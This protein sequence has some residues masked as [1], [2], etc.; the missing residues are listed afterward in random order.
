MN[1]RCA[2]GV[3]AWRGCSCSRCGKTRNEGHD[4]AEN[5]ERCSICG[6]TRTNHNW[7]RDCEK[8]ANCRVTRFS[9]HDWSK[10]CEKCAA[11]GRKR[12]NAHDWSQDVEK[13]A[14]C[15][16]T[17]VMPFTEEL[18][19][20]HGLDRAAHCIAFSRDDNLIAAGDDHGYI[21][22]WDLRKKEQMLKFRAHKALVTDI[23]FAQDDTLLVSAANDS[24]VC[25]LDARTGGN[26]RR[27]AEQFVPPISLTCSPNGRLLAVC[28]RRDRVRMFRL[29]TCELVAAGTVGVK[30]SDCC[31]ERN[32]AIQFSTHVPSLFVGD[33]KGVVVYDAIKLAEIK[34]LTDWH[35]PGPP[36]FSFSANGK[37][38]A[39][40][41]T[42]GVVLLDV[43]D[44]QTRSTVQITKTNVLEFGK[45]SISGDGRYVVVSR[46]DGEGVYTPVGTYYTLE[47]W[48][49]ADSRM[50]LSIP[51]VETINDMAFSSTGRLFAT[52]S[53]TKR[54]SLE[55]GDGPCEVRVWKCTCS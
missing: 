12:Q 13:C 1:M 34:R 52:G 33:S 4:W 14:K 18:P 40:D 43:S 23:V 21:I 19:P 10:D 29:P 55:S 27:I 28:D 44:W 48:R 26:V 30:G 41:T 16:T 54:R 53:C 9:A 24:T 39:A 7:S 11:C 50:V 35:N 8:C 25:L 22:V 37:Y 49:V 38:L 51:H 31:G 6:K 36:S 3:H 32:I 45:V 47:V 17:R 5:C 20:F 2:I 42:A 46:Y 15:G